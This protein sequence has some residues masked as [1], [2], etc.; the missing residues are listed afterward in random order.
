MATAN[1]PE[2]PA[3]HREGLLARHPLIFYFIMAYAGTWL[4]TVPVALSANGVGLLPFGIPKG[5]VIFVSA[6]WVFLG[7]TL[8]AFIVTGATEGRAGIRCLLRRYVLW[9]VGL[10]WYLVVLLGPP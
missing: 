4:V 1:A 2:R 7:P 3:T 8:A 10:R 5:S 6:V 9:R